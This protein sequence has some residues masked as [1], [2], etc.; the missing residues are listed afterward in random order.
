MLQANSKV[1]RLKEKIKH[2]EQQL[3]T[4]HDKVQALQ[5]Q[6]Q[7]QQQ[8]SQHQQLQQAQQPQ[9]QPTAQQSDLQD[10]LAK[11][12]LR[13]AELLTDNEAALQQL[14]QTRSRAVAAEEQQQHLSAQ[15]QAERQTSNSLQQQLHSAQQQ[16]QDIQT[17]AQAIQQQG[18]QVAHQ[19]HAQGV[20][21]PQ[22]LQLLLRSSIQEHLERHRAVEMQQEHGL[23][24]QQLQ[25][26]KEEL[27][28]G[29]HS[30]CDH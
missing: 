17:Q 22:D 5:Q 25:Q 30:A 16:L 20:F 14:Q 21:N 19:A 15:L 26:T 29:G 23:L 24:M 27:V 11:C 2:K 10:M 3:T 6:L 12:K 4:Q 1:D 28:T 18:N 7:Q 13:L 9:Q 8:Q